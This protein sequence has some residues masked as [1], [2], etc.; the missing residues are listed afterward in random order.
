MQNVKETVRWVIKLLITSIGTCIVLW[1]MIIC[2]VSIIYAVD[3]IL[4]LPSLNKVIEVKGTEIAKKTENRILEGAKECNE[5]VTLTLEDSE[6]VR[7]RIYNDALDQAKAK[8]YIDFIHGRYLTPTNWISLTCIITE[9]EITVSDEERISISLLYSEVLQL[10][11]ENK[12]IKFFTEIDHEKS[13]FLSENERKIIQDCI[14]KQKENTDLYNL[15][16]MVLNDPNVIKELEKTEAYNIEYYKIREYNKGEHIAEDEKIVT[17]SGSVVVIKKTICHLSCYDKIGV[18][19]SYIANLIFIK[20]TKLI[21]Q[22]PKS[23][24]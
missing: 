22:S 12:I 24:P 21:D 3:R 14:N 8:G 2:V 7:N 20:H 11:T 10:L 5:K 15:M 18:V 9:D 19:G 4:L 23:S 17:L 1:L 16:Y 13:I 6:T